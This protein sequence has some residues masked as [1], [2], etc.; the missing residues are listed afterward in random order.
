[1]QRMPFRDGGAGG[2]ADEG[3]A[4][5]SLGQRP[6]QS[7]LTSG[8]CGCR[9]DGPPPCCLLA[10]PEPPAGQR[11]LSLGSPGCLSLRCEP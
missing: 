2:E 6:V 4:T 8:L 5:S 10:P 11:Q 9:P 1:M 3:S 7:G